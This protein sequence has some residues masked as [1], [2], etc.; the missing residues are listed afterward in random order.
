MRHLALILGLATASVGLPPASAQ[1]DI[2]ARVPWTTYEAEAAQ[3]NGSLLGPDYKG[4]TAA[5]EAS[6]RR[7]VRL[8]ST[9]DHLEF[10]AT[11]DG[12]G[13]VVRYSLPDKAADA[14][15]S[16]SINGQPPTKLK[17]TSRLSHL[18]GPYPFSNDASL[19]SPRNFWDEV[20]VAGV[21]IRSGDLVRI[22]IAEDDTARDV[23]ID[24]ID[25]E[26]VPAPL[27]QPA[28]AVSITD[29]GATPNDETEDTDAIRAAIDAA[30]ARNK[31]LYL[32]PGTFIV[33]GAIDLADVTLQGA[34]I[35]HTTLEGVDDYTPAD[36]VSLNGVGSNVTLA[37]FS[38]LGKLD[39]RNDAE[40]N[41]A[42]GGSFGTGSVIRN[43]WIEHT[44]AGIWV[45]NSDGLVVENCRFRNL[46]AD[47][48]NLCVGMKN[49]TVRH[50]T[51][52]G[53]GDDC[54]AMWPA[55]YTKSTFDHGNNRY[56]N[57]T[58]QLPFLAQGF[59]IYGGDSNR[60]ENCLSIDIPYGAGLFASTTFPTER[61][62]VG[63]TTFANNRIVR[64][65][66][67]EGAIGTVANKRDL[68]G[69]RFTNNDIV[70]SPNDA[71]RFMS[72]FGGALREAGIDGIR[73][74][75][76]G[77]AGAGHGIVSA[78]DAVGAVSIR[79][80]V[81]EGAKS[82]GFRNVAASFDV[83]KGEHTS[84]LENTSALEE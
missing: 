41:D 4:M 77:I 75:N 30:K 49:T 12:Q 58:A 18:Y 28:G 33:R 6:G 63:V 25:I 10:R 78:D 29:H 76:A 43:L 59:S 14:T 70:D 32:T 37:D 26:P 53:T 60:V 82:G 35:W 71:V 22:E 81:I 23:L 20:R 83:T 45:V 79:D 42:V 67:R 47:G 8:A 40:P 48:M 46:I 5:R 69:I 64:A 3:T 50:C 52:R 68:V 34:G 38:I 7:C 17:L 51:A 56:V 31:V 11:N 62:F 27:A 39:Y 9:G 16:L 44:K 13:V 80:V 74:R 36:R 24:L 19:G 66:D 72:V 2:G 15:V 55:T 57:C 54:F 21:D 73:I 65:G 61:G 84:A 1:A